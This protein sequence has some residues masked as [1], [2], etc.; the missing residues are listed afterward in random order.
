[1]TQ[2]INPPSS[3]LTLIGNTA[4]W[5]LEREGLG[6]SSLAT[7]A[8][9]GAIFFSDCLAGGPG[10]EANLSGAGLINMTDGSATVSTAVDVSPTVLEC[11][12]GT[13][14]P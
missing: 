11:Y 6:G 7:L 13:N 12:Y 3:G 1:M 9:Y 2:A 5:I 14:Q 8:N 4:E 10:F